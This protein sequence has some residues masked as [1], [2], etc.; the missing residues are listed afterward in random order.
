MARWVSSMGASTGASTGA[1]TVAME[2]VEIVTRG[3]RRSYTADEKAALL[4]E[5]AA[6]GVRVLAVAQRHGVERWP[7]ESGQVG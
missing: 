6:P 4:A 5:A 7:K 1:G 3:G 2:R